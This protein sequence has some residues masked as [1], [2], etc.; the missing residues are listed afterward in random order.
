VRTVADLLHDYQ[1][2]IDEVVV[3]AGSR[4]VFDVVVDGEVLF[5]KH[6]EGRHAA[7]GEV[8]ERFRAHVGPG[9]PVYERD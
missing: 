8:L 9:V 6:R 1:H 4:G 3:R 5:S 7:P 2:V